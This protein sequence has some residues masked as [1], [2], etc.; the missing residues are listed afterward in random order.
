MVFTGA[1]L[2][3]L[4]VRCVGSVPDSVG[5]LESSVEN[6]PLVPE[7]SVRYVPFANFPGPTLRSSSPPVAS[8]AT[9]AMASAPARA[10][11]GTISVPLAELADHVDAV[12]AT[13]GAPDR[14]ALP[15]V[16]TADDAGR[17]AIGLAPT[18]AGRRGP[19]EAGAHV[20]GSDKFGRAHLTA[21]S[22]AG[23]VGGTVDDFILRQ[24]KDRAQ[25]SIDMAAVPVAANAAG[26][27][28]FGSTP[29]GRLG[30]GGE[31]VDI[32]GSG[33]FIE[34]MLQ[35]TL[36]D[37]ADTEGFVAETSDLD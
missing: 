33:R 13:Q 30:V 28:G 17:V 21:E 29:R 23:S 32:A 19:L 14:F 2:V 18:A 20:S 27:A 1:C 10:R 22:G 31:A 12:A 26:K 8:A 7:D 37:D 3:D 16:R 5:P 9:A 24:A 34:G 36:S 15:S 35:G 4:R 6:L 25:G 11:S